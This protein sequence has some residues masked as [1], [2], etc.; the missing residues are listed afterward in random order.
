MSIF[1]HLFGFGSFGFSQQQQAASQE[2]AYHS[3]QKQLLKNN[4]ASKSEDSNIIDAE[5]E[6]IEE[7]ETNLLENKQ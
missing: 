2:A 4:S 7:S 1:N 5:F 3:Y 6:V